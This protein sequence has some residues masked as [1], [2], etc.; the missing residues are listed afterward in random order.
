MTF[1][2]PFLLFGLAAAAI[3]IIIHLLNLRKLKVVEFSSLQ[4]LKEL[5]K[6]TMRRVKIR[7]ILLLILRTLLIVL[8]VLAFARPALKGSVGS[9]GTHAKST[10]VI[11]LDDS[12]SMSVRDEKGVLFHQ[13]TAAVANLLDLVKEGDE[14][15][16]FKLSETRHKQVFPPSSISTVKSSLTNMAPSL[17]TAPFRDAFGVAAK[18]LGESKNFNQEVYL[19]TDAQ[20]TQFLPLSA[21]D[22]SNMFDDRAHVF[23]ITTGKA[24]DNVGIGTLEVKTQIIA[25][26]KPV[27]LKGTV[28]NFG[29]SPL[30]N[31]LASMYIDG[32]RV[33][34]QTLE[35]VAGGSSS[36]DFTVT[37]KRRGMMAGYLQL[38]D[39]ILEAD[40]K[41]YFA[42]DVPENINVLLVG[43]KQEDTRLPSLALTVGGDSSL[44]GL[45]NVSRTT[46]GQLSSLDINKVDVLV[47][48]GIKE[49]TATEADRVARFVR[50][51]G[52]IMLFP[53]DE[54]DIPNLNETVFA[55]LGIPPCGGAQGSAT[56]Q[57][58]FLTFDKID[59]DHALFEGMFQQPPIGKKTHARIESPRIYKTVMPRAGENGHTIIALSD[60]TSFLTEYAIGTGRVLLISVEADIGWSDFPVKGLFAPLLHR[61]M[62]YLAGSQQRVSKGTVGEPV[63]ATIRL[64]NSSNTLFTCTSPS[65]VEE[66]LVPQT[67]TA[68]GLSTFTSSPTTETGLYT[69][70]SAGNILYA[71]AINIDPA[72][73]DLRR[74][75]A[76]QLHAFWQHIGIRPTRVHELSASDKLEA[77]VQESRLGVELWKYCVLLAGLVAVVEMIVAREPRTA[78]QSP[79]RS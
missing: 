30:H 63:R 62:M 38:D 44:G 15:Y 40:N 29:S 55:R 3:P 79:V 11:I 31:V 9:I 20:A 13:A 45:F 4:F 50:A 5:Q 32:T 14:L 28:R 17:E 18:I 61:S 46:Q 71:T 73:S 25:R 52:G 23:V 35:I 21:A 16:F 6:T 49:F 27:L 39:D 64:K 72:E 42:L 66:R 58:S 69:L 77:A 2:N 54:T 47:F 7:Q 34:Q 57:T 70:Q 10:V 53:D 36:V 65:G 74:V 22:S 33:M 8:L 75:S 78:L 26:N 43:G 59:Y 1:L 19:V 51:G 60:G 24:Q 37:P 41:R 48:C 67:N 68:T 56:G 12:P 76:D